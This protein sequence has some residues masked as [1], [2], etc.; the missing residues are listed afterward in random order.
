MIFQV[1]GR[2]LPCTVACPHLGCGCWSLP[3]NAPCRLFR[4]FGGAQIPYSPNFLDLSYRISNGFTLSQYDSH[5]SLFST[6]PPGGLFVPAG[7]LQGTVHYYHS[8]P[9]CHGGARAAPSPSAA[10]DWPFCAAETTFAKRT[11]PTQLCCS[12][13]VM[14]RPDWG[15][16]SCSQG[17]LF[18]QHS[19]A[20]SGHGWPDGKTCPARITATVPPRPHATSLSSLVAMRSATVAPLWV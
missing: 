4:T 6:K 19:P 15:S 20:G 11:A 7:L 14:C 5:E 8:L 10:A 9:L 13:V 12:P 17:L 18:S 3:F 2:P 1:N 16:S